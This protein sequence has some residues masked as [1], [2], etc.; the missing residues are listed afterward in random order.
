MYTHTNTQLEIDKDD[1]SHEFGT[2]F[3]E[4]QGFSPTAQD[5]SP[6]RK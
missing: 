2:M 1:I 6:V 3:R 5:P 4:Q